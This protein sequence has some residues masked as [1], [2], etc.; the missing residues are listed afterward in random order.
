MNQNQSRVIDIRLDGTEFAQ[1]PSSAC[2]LSPMRVGGGEWTPKSTL[3]CGCKQ[4][5]FLLLI[6]SSSKPPYK[7]GALGSATLEFHYAAVYVCVCRQKLGRCVMVL[8]FDTE[9]VSHFNEDSG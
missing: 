7:A 3:C 4:S 2:F 6:S 8:G 5:E 1:I 9:A